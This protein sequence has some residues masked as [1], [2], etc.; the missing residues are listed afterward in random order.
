YTA[1]ALMAAINKALKVFRESP[2]QIHKMQ[3]TAVNL[4]D[5]KFTWDQIVLRY[6]ELY[7]KALEMLP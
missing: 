5:K 1:E 3:K 7:K 2:E 4:V 6:L